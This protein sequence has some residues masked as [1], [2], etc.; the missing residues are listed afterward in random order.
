MKGRE[1][2]VPLVGPEVVSAVIERLNAGRRVRRT[3]AGGGRLHVDRPLPFL[4][5][6]RSPADR[7]DGGTRRLILGQPSYLA[8]PADAQEEALQSFVY[9]IVEPLSRSAGAFLIVEV[10]SSAESEAESAEVPL[11]DLYDRGPRIRVVT[12]D[13]QGDL[14]AVQTLI[15]ELGR[16]TLDGSA[17]SVEHTDA[18]S[19]SPPGRP[20]LLEPDKANQLDCYVVGVEI[21]PVYRDRTTGATYPHV[22][23]ELARQLGDAL[24]HAF[25]RFAH[26]KTESR[27][28]SP[29]GLGRRAVVR[30]VH[31]VDEELATI[32]GAYD[33]LLAVT[34]V[35]A[36]EEWEAFSAGGFKD[37][38]TFR[39]RRLTH[40]PE[41]L[42]RRLYAVPLENME[43]P[44]LERIFR[45]KV[46]EVAR[47]LTMLAERNTHR[48]LYGSL[49]LYGEVEDE[50]LR[51]AGGI[52]AGVTEDEG[53]EDRSVGAVEFAELAQKFLDDFRAHHAALTAT[54]E[55]R[56]DTSSLMVTKG[57]LLVPSVLRLSPGRALA[58]AHHEAGTHVLTWANGMAQPLA[59]LHTGLAGY[60]A[61]QEGL[62]V[63]SEYL[64]GGLTRSRLRLLAGRVVAAARVI[65][66]ASF[67][68]I[69]DELTTTHGLTPRT[70]FSTTMRVRR[71][72]GLTKDIVYL[73]GL[74]T[75]LEYLAGNGDIEILFL[76]KMA[77]RHVPLVQELRAREVLRPPPLRPPCLDVPGA[78]EKLAWLREGRTVLDL[79]E[80]TFP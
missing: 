50:L 64:V 22:V 78:Q 54:V 10:W 16:V 59:L 71:S 6:Y 25:F 11:A 9:S 46:R 44:T 38:P 1:S 24:R 52:L 55:V 3:I 58:L 48:F 76:G 31:A 42:L 19:A 68:A 40:D 43:D 12:P 23:R 21:E 30:A 7:E 5:V 61:L 17:A 63:L 34:P 32:C 62:A 74:V 28:D 69:F 49:Q 14:A 8:L 56:A 72:G 29:L 20:P 53:E 70:A 66:G 33:F 27:P 26:E 67:A 4:V 35:N 15:R 80:T 77:L 73:R 65:E 51:L 75:L 37:E 41:L 36:T 18:K 47:Q 39:Y 2:G 45:E 13:P 60:E 57:R 79:P